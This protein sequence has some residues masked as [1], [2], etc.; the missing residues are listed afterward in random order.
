LTGVLVLVVGPSGAGKDTLIGAARSAFDG[1]PRFHFVRRTITRSADAGGET[2]T[3][4]TVAEFE[5]L[6][7]AGAFCLTWRANGLC[8]GLTTDVPTNL[9]AGKVVIANASRAIV[10]QAALR[11]PSLRVVQVT[12]PPAVL[13]RR[14]AERGRES[15]ARVQDRLERRPAMDL[16][17][18]DAFEIDNS[19]PPPIAIAAM[20][21]YL[22]RLADDQAASSNRSVNR[23][24]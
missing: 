19:G 9:G 10:A 22:R 18:L 16:G 21:G 6:E 7:R 24:A 17:R 11:F 3:P 13:A 23:N 1:D 2:H 4:A 20:V 12:A 8:Y 5:T 14:L 15:V